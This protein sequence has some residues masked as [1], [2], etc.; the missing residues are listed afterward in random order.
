MIF[1]AEK[2]NM[3][4]ALYGNHKPIFLSPGGSDE[5]M[6]FYLIRKQ[7]NEKEF[8]GYKK[9]KNVII[10]LDEILQHCNDAKSIVAVRLYE[11]LKKKNFKY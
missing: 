2:I 10:K 8:E 4:D 9:G 3:N 5:G 6:T 7:V 1:F 11:T